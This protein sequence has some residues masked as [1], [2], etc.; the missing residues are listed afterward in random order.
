MLT[1]LRLILALTL[2]L[3][4]CQPPPAPPAPP[5][6]PIAAPVVAPTPEPPLAVVP[7]AETGRRLLARHHRHR[8]DGDSQ[9]PEGG[10]FAPGGSLR[11]GSINYDQPTPPT[12]YGLYVYALPERN[13]SAEMLAAL[14]KFH[15]CLS[16]PGSGEAAGAIALL[17]LPI[18]QGP[19]G[20][21]IDVQF[22]HDLLRA[23]PIQS[24]DNQE[25]YFVATNRPLRLHD[26]T[27]GT[28]VM[29]LGHIAP[30]YLPSW[31][32][33]FQDNIESGAVAAPSRW[34]PAIKSAGLIV[35]SVGG[36]FG[37]ASAHATETGCG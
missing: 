24:L 4:G 21:H 9:L 19:D 37:V 14:L 2:V 34:L 1:E 25:V 32:V 11:S 22:A 6:P 16:K 5:P 31:L 33:D 36:L 17:L 10:G 27:P 28:T 29:R 26:P 35:V 12:G 23:I 15:G 3:A 8:R 30:A 13:V 7:P 18:R 20:D